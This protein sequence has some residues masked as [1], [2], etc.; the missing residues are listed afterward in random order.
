M[1]T[2]YKNLQVSESASQVVIKAAYK[3]LAQKWHPDKN[4]DQREKAELY[5]RLIN[6]AF[7]V[8][9]DYIEPVPSDDAV[10]GDTVPGPEESAVSDIPDIKESY[11]IRRCFAREVDWAFS[12]LLCFFIYVIG[13]NIY[14]ADTKFNVLFTD[15]KVFVIFSFVSVIL[16]E[17]IS[18]NMFGTTLGKA[19][20]GVFLSMKDGE[21]IGLHDSFRRALIA[22]VFGD[23]LLIPGVSALVNLF[24]YYK[25]RVDK[26]PA[27]D[28]EI[29][30]VV[31]YAPLRFFNWVLIGFMILVKLIL[32]M[33][34]QESL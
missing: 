33:S 6:R 2:H 18:I 17:S 14:G 4:P 19:V 10:H 28:V 3:A 8:R 22:N 11:L 29:G 31:T 23:G 34:L 27:W 15:W 24:W 5:F 9:E 20:F 30:T 13:C 7:E 32:L 21:K 16:V 26:V 1:R 12:L 25:I